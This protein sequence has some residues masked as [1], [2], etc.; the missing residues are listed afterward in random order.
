MPLLTSSLE[1][2]KPN[3]VSSDVGL[4]LWYLLVGGEL[5]AR[6]VHALAAGV[7]ALVTCKPFRRSRKMFSLYVLNRVPDS[8]GARFCLVG[9]VHVVLSCCNFDL[10]ACPL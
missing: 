1:T 6:S 8:S 5:A 9:S 7:A 4:Q 10:V 2:G 3:G